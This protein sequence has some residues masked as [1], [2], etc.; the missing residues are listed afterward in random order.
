MARPDCDVVR[1]TGS[2]VCYS[3]NAPTTTCD[4][5]RNVESRGSAAG[6]TFVAAVKATGCRKLKIVALWT[7][8]CVAFPALDALAEGFEDRLHGRGFLSAAH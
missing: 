6:A 7:E 4:G 3:Y 8:V 1:E 2:V 5:R